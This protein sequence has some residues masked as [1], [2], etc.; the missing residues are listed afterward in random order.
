MA[1]K[2]RVSNENEK[3][4]RAL[5]YLLRH[6]AEK[7][8]FRLLPG[9]FLYVDDI[10]KHSNFYPFSMEDVQN[11]V[12]SN[13][14]KRFTLELDSVTGRLKIRANQGHSLEVNDLDLEP[15]TDASDYPIVIHGTYL[16]PFKLIKKEGLKRMG[17]NHVH[18]AAG[19]PGKDGVISG[20]RKSCTVT[21]YLN[22]AKALEDGLKFY[23][24][25]N[26]VILCPGN[27]EGVIPPIYFDKVIERKTGELLFSEGKSLPVPT[28]E[29]NPQAPG[30]VTAEDIAKEFDSKKGRKTNHRKKAQ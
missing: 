4:S 23:L 11:V 21:I 12:E 8:G 7:E 2:G 18:F 1:G 16:R 15:I 27:D 13:D 24:S 14:K 26:K 19:E 28:W 6:G 20:M 22:L 3:L 29:F 5:S 9:G 17:R 10:L 30:V 25:A